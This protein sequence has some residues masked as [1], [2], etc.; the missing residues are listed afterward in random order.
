MEQGVTEKRT[1]KEETKSGTKV[2]QQTKMKTKGS[3][4]NSATINSGSGRGQDK[5]IGQG[6][7]QKKVKAGKQCQGR[8]G[9]LTLIS[10][11]F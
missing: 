11:R 9:S 1:T 6:S 7:V 3:I 10:S 8:E 5:H 4:L 2:H